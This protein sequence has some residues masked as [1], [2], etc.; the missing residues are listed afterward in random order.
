VVLLRL[1]ITRPR[2]QAMAWV[3]ALQLQLRP[4]VPA[5]V[6]VEVDV[7][8]LPLLAI[9]PAPEAG[10]VR[11][12]WQCVPAM[13]QVMF[14]SSNA[15]EQFFALKPERAGWP[16]STRAGATGPGTTAALRKAGVPAE[17]IDQPAAEAGRFD[18]EALWQ[19][20]GPR[21]WQGQDVLVVRGQQGRDWLADQWQAAGARVHFVQAYQRCAERWTDVEL[22]L[23]REAHNAPQQH[24]WHF[25]SSESVALLPALAVAAG[26]PSLAMPHLAMPHPALAGSTVL[27]TH[28]RI[29]QALRALGVPEVCVIAPTREAV[30]LHVQARAGALA[31][32]QSAP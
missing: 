26:V 13:R 32:G 1:L 28:E 8:A 3:Q 6:R 7:Q 14:V 11:A 12:A 4:H 2:A 21:A 15:V 30:L 29:G 23:V 19:L 5:T 16:A 17:L 24:L 22:K 27:A 10:P 20:I 9:E 31:L 25:S 18:S